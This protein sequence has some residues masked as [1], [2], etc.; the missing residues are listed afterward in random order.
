MKIT[1]RHSAAL[2]LL[3]FG[4]NELIERKIITLDQNQK[5]VPDSGEFECNYLDGTPCVVGYH[6]I[7]HGE[8]GVGVLYGIKNTGLSAL[9]WP[10]VSSS[11]YAKAHAFSWLERQL[12]CYIQ[13]V[14]DGKIQLGI[15]CSNEV[16]AYL[17]SYDVA[18]RFP[19]KKGGKLVL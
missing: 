18:P 12:D 17:S 16:K 7:G 19:F 2:N 9:T 4:V 6:D 3:A 14:R 15:Y 11:K 10:R 5:P 13:D 1:E 8:I